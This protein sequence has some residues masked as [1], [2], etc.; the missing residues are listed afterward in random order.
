M[1]YVLK[2][3]IGFG[4]ALVCILAVPEICETAHAGETVRIGLIA[5]LSGKFAAYGLPSKRAA[6]M[7][8][9]AVNGQAG[10]KKIDLIVRDVQSDPQVM[11]AVMKELADQQHVDFLVGP[12]AS[13]IVATGVPSWRQSK[14]LWIVPGSSSPNLEKEIGDEPLYFH[15]YPYAYNYHV[16]AAEGLRHYLGP[17]RR[18]AVIYADDNFGRSHLDYVRKYYGNAGFKIVAEE[19]VRANAPD[20]RPNLARIRAAKPDVLVAL[21]ETTDAVTLAKEVRI[22]KLGVPYLLGTSFAQYNEWQNAVG[23]AQEGWLGV[24]TYLPGVLDRPGDPNAPK[25]FP[26]SKEWEATFRK[27]YNAEPDQLAASTYVSVAMIIRAVELCTCDDKEKVAAELRKMEVM[28]VFGKGKFHPSEG[29][30]LQQAYDQMVLF[31]RHNGKSVVVY[32]IDV[33]QADLMPINW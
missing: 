1:A 8:V 27:L 4:L 19:M 2:S 33:R 28:T 9:A 13:P 31:Q 24:S 21:V 7:A 5:E 18:M 22:V 16:V 20:M 11:V 32:P 12:I 6:E 25:L 23:E 17:N 14:P 3:I 26:S 15:A 29:G 30:T 10:G